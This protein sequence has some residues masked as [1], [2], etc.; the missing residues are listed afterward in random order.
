M[1]RLELAALD[2][3]LDRARVD[4]EQRGC[5][6]RGQQPGCD[7]RFV[8]GRRLGPSRRRVLGG[9]G[10]R[11]GLRRLRVEERKRE[12]LLR[13]DIGCVTYQYLDSESTRR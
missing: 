12:L 6:V 4:V 8:D 10:L 7:L 9:R 5:L 3:A 11:A 13:Y 1:D 2:E